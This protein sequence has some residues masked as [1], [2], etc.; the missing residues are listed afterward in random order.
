MLQYVHVRVYVRVCACVCCV[1]T[2]AVGVLCTGYVMKPA[3]HPFWRQGEETCVC[4]CECRGT[5]VHVCSCVWGGVCVRT[6][7]ACAMC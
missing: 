3:L 4:V 6:W 5:F 2:C 1:C 7:L